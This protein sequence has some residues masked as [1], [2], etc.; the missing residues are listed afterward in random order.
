MTELVCFNVT[1]LPTLDVLLEISGASPSS[2]FGFKNSFFPYVTKLDIS[3]RLPLPF[4]NALDSSHEIKDGSSTPVIEDALKTWSRLSSRITQLKELH[5]IRICLDHTSKPYWSVV[6]E[7]AVL[8]QFEPLASNSDL[9]LVF[10]LP[11]LHPSLEDP[12]RHYIEEKNTT[13][14]SFASLSQFKIRR[15][16]RQRRQSKKNCLGH[17]Q[18]IYAEDFPHLLGHPGVRHRSLLWVE[19]VER[20][21]WRAGQDVISFSS[22]LI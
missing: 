6:N 12:Q 17:Y 13:D 8:S 21:M 2:P 14:R 5:S 19:E 16:L 10:V 1:D 7:R 3:L 22:M 11:K 15:I 18:V 20:A 4:F 9:D